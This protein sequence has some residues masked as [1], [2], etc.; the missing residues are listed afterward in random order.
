MTK[1]TFNAGTLAYNATE[2]VNYVLSG[3]KADIFS[4]GAVFLE[5]LTVYSGQQQLQEFKKFRDGSYAANIDKAVKW[6]ETLCDTSLSNSLPW[7]STMLFLREQ[8][9][10]PD[11]EQRPH[12]FDIWLC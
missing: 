6:I 3:R 7:Y 11:K 8:R 1:D 2:T 4:L 12:I 5:M 9:L 10:L